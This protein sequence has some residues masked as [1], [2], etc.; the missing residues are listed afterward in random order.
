M[1][2]PRLTPIVLLALAML[3]GALPA[4][5]VR[6]AVAAN[7]AGVLDRL[8]EGFSERTGHH[9]V[10]SSASTG[11]HYAQIR[12]GAKFDL[13]LAADAQRPARL[14]REGLGV[15]G[16]RF[17]YAQGRLVLWAPGEAALA[18]PRDYLAAAPFRRLAIANPRLAPYGLAAQQVLGHWQ[19]W[20]RLQDRLVSG[21]NVAQA[22]Q[23]VATGNAQAGLVALAQVLALAPDARGAYSPIPQGLH[24]PIDQQALLLRDSAAA[25]A[26]IDYLKSDEAAVRIREAGYLVPGRP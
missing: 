2:G 26:F 18:D 13:F 5:E 8:A 24:D 6:V 14:E 12:N 21:E 19:L 15:A 22:V 10:V 20:D 7:F 11:K 4:A 1:P 25:R 9:V 16:T 17:S 3:P 23:F